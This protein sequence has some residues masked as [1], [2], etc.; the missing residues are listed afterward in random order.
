MNISSVTGS[1]KALEPV[2]ILVKGSNDSSPFGN[3]DFCAKWDDHDPRNP[4]NFSPWVKRWLLFQMTFLATVSSFG[5]SVSG[6]AGEDIAAYLDVS[7]EVI[8][9]DIALF[10]L[11]WA[12]GPVI[13]APIG[14]VYGRKASMLPAVFIMGLFSIGSGTSTTAAA[15]FASEFSPCS[16]LTPQYI[17][18]K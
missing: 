4:L 12:F 3:E 1:Q 16:L 17:G 10:M 9:L 14:E 8:V 6:P 15:L 5:S 11:G 7:P 2:V 13:W 18:H